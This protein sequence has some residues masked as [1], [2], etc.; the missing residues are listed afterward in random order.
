MSENPLQDEVWKRNFRDALDQQTK[1]IDKLLEDL[2]EEKQA[3]RG[4]APKQE[5]PAV[6]TPQDQ[7]PVI[8]A[9]ENP[10]RVSFTKTGIEVS[11]LLTD[12]ASADELISTINAL[13]YLL[14]PAASITPA[15]T[16]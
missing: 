9:D 6:Y 10:Y 4:V 11:A 12:L 2:Q 14:P 3:R 7:R 5:K 15:S 8:Q 13:K 1:Q 16:S